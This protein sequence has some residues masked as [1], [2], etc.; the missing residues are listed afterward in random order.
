[1]RHY[2]S[3]L[4][5]TALALLLISFVAMPEHTLSKKAKVFNTQEA[6]EAGEAGL[7]FVMGFVEGFLKEKSDGI[8]SCEAGA[9]SIA[10]TS[11][12]V[13]NAFKG[14]QDV[15]TEVE[16]VVSVVSFLLTVPN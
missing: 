3:T 13:I 15:V 4:G 7:Q 2:K 16:A 12:S 11:S 6:I 8:K 5:K 9:K 14:R 10:D 1:M